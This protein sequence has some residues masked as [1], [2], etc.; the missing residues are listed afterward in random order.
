[1]VELPDDSRKLLTVDMTSLGDLK[2][3]VQPYAGD[4]KTG[5]YNILRANDNVLDVEIAFGGKEGGDSS[6][7]IDLAALREGNDQT[8]AGLFLKRS[9]SA[10]TI[11]LQVSARSP[12]PFDR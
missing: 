2:K 12:L 8:G 5:D 11:F 9:T 4:E 7:C 10:T 1:M 3:A 6:L